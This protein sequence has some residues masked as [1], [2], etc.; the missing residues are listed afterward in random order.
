MLHPLWPDA[1]TAEELKQG[2]ELIRLGLACPPGT[3]REAAYLETLGS[4]YRDATPDQHIDRLKAL[5][6]AAGAQALKFPEDLDAQAFSALFHLAPARFQAKDKSNRLQ[7]EAVEQLQAVLAKIPDH[8]GAQHYKIHALDFPML[9]DR[10][11]EVCDTYGGI[12]P[13]VPHALHMPTHI[14]T[15]RGQWAKSIEF[16]RRSAEAGRRLDQ[17]TGVVNSHQPHAFDYLAYA[18][19]QLGQYT[20]AD[21]VRRELLALTGPYS[22]V[23]T[24]AVAFAFAATPARC[25]LEQQRWADAAKLP[26]RQP[27]QFAWGAQYL[28]CESITHFARAI[29]AARSKNLELARSEIAELER[30][31]HQ[32][33]TAK[34]AAY[35]ASQA[36]TQVLA[37]RAWVLH[38]EGKEGEAIELMQRA[39]ALEATTD[40]EAV[41]P[42]EVLP[43]GDLLG[44]LLLECGKPGEA[45]AA[46]EAVNVASPNRLNTIYGAGLAAE[47]SGDLAKASRYYE[48]VVTSAAEGDAGI[49]RVEKARA[50][51]KSRRAPD[52]LAAR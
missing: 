43:A 24:A 22:P 38:A 6:K 25:L 16:N 15:R 11:L 29:G 14:Y 21:E 30:I 52:P 3:P 20:K 28:N 31:A 32:L 41:T 23:Q 44:D 4:Y 8:P 37:S 33:A 34:K 13:D 9:A 1:P 2:A 27:A 17:T 10:A 26:L 36:Q 47:Q 51:L 50:F 42:G 7:I 5:D 40:K 18:Y 45:L 12:A 49:P 46:F 19:L 35:W 48:Q 39:V